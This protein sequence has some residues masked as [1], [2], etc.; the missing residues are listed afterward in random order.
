MTDPRHFTDNFDMLVA[1]VTNLSLD[2][3]QEART[4]TGISKEL[5]LDRA[6]VQAVFDGFPCF[7]RQ[8]KNTDATTGEHYYEIHA[9][10]ARRVPPPAG[11]SAR[12]TP[13]PLPPEELS[14][15]FDLITN[16]VKTES[17]SADLRQRTEASSADLRSK[18]RQI[19]MTLIVALL[20]AGAAIVSAFIKGTS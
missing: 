1:L 7:F 11:S 2:P 12:P 10:Y 8:S 16:M 5:Q 4:A 14:L 17:Q 13:P 15:M 19:V 9:R 20:A 18:N 3:D 6:A